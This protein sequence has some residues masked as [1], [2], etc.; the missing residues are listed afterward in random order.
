MEIFFPLDSHQI[1]MFVFSQFHINMRQQ[2]NTIL[3]K[4]FHLIAWETQEQN[5]KNW[6]VDRIPLC[7]CLF[8]CFF[9]VFYSLFS[10]SWIHSQLW[11]GYRHCLPFGFYTV[12]DCIYRCVCFV[13][14][15]PVNVDG[16]NHPAEKIKNLMI[17]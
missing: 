14:S 5:R 2:P 1:L 9:F 3:I 13:I 11:I 10:S 15:S 16:S 8:G 6:F 17:I 12:L 7:V 4:I